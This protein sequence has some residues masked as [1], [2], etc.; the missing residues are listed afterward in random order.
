MESSASWVMVEVA[1]HTPTVLLLIAIFSPLERLFSIHTQP[2]L[3]PRLWVDFAFLIGQFSLWGSGTVVALLWVQ[4]TLGEYDWIHWVHGYTHKLPLGLLLVLGVLVSD[5]CIYWGHRLS[6]R[7]PILWSIHRVHHTARSLDWVAAYRE[8][9][10]DHLYTRLIE[11]V[12]LLILGI[13]LETLAGFFVF[14]G[15]WALWIHSNADLPIGPLKYLCGCPHL[16][17]WHHDEVTEGRYNYANLMPLMDLLFG[18][19]YAPKGYPDQY[20]VD[21]R[22]H[23]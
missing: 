12:P 5:F 22:D 2:T 3:R 19:Y 23:H 14:R 11:N 4:S 7:I 9:P 16:H 15:L 13:P 8:H 18:T 1:R 10:L 6:H 20:G 21:Q 17:H